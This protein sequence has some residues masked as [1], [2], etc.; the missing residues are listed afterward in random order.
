[1]AYDLARERQLQKGIAEPAEAPSMCSQ[2]LHRRLKKILK[3]TMQQIDC[4]LCRIDPTKMSR[5]TSMPTLPVQHRCTYDEEGFIRADWLRFVD[6]VA[7]GGE[8]RRESGRPSTVEM[9]L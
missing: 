9:R 8:A 6:D 3:R 4:S 5:P 1:M 7:L 2:A